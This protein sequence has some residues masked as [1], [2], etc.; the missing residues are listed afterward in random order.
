MTYHFKN[1]FSLLGLGTTLI[2]VAFVAGC[3]GGGG[4]SSSP[5]V[6]PAPS[7][8][9]T[10][11]NAI[12]TPMD[13]IPTDGQAPTGS[14]TIT[15]GRASLQT[16][17]FL[18]KSVVDAVQAAIN[19]GL[20][21]AGYVRAIPNNQVPSSIAFTGSGQVDGNG[22]LVLTAKKTVNI[23]GEATLTIDPTFASNGTTSSGAGTY[24][25]TFPNNLVI[26]LSGK[27][28]VAG[29]CNNLPL[30]SGSVTFGR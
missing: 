25:I 30:R 6:P 1:K 7:P 3:G 2:A 24:Q 11:Y 17:F 10:S 28:P 5:S 29:T 18:Q 19:K 22:K 13:V 8:F 14:L 20:T 26:E 15:G 9:D 16:T 4:G 12:Y 23:C 27:R 21:D